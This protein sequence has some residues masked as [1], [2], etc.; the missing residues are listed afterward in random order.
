MFIIIVILY[1]YVFFLSFISSWIAKNKRIIILSLK[2]YKRDLDNLIVEI[3][4]NLKSL[5]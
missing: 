4:F 5:L 3:Q 2:N 1:A